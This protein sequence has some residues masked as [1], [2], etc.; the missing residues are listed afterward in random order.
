MGYQTEFEGTFNIFP[1]LTPEHKEILD[2][3]AEMRHHHPKNHNR[4]D[5]NKPDAFYCQ[6]VVDEGGSVLGWDGSEKFYNYTEWLEYLI[7]KFFG[8]WGYLLNGEV[9]FR[10]E[11]FSDYGTIFVRNNRVHVSHKFQRYS[12]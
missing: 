6:W 2:E 8:P 3:F 4:P 11:E 5:P 1:S 7:R 10:G 9:R 12:D